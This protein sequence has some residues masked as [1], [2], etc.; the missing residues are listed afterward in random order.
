MI[1]VLKRTNDLA[2]LNVNLLM[3]QLNQISKMISHLKWNMFLV[4]SSM[5]T[6]FKSS[7][8]KICEL[9]IVSNK[10][11]EKKNKITKFHTFYTKCPIFVVLKEQTK[12]YWV[13][14][15]WPRKWK[16]VMNYHFFNVGEQHSYYCSCKQ[17]IQLKICNM[18]NNLCINLG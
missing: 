13:L 2:P 12:P 7:W 8:K 14:T 10:P 15:R 16:N 4:L 1:L 9:T 17:K 18:H 11:I 6:I 3:K 5:S